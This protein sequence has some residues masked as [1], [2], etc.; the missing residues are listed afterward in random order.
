LVNR[1]FGIERIKV[2]LIGESQDLLN[3]AKMLLDEFRDEVILVQEPK[4]LAGMKSLER[5][6]PKGYPNMYIICVTTSDVVVNVIDKPPYETLLTNAAF[7]GMIRDLGMFHKVFWF[8]EM[9]QIGI[10]II[11]FPDYNGFSQSS[12]L[13]SCEALNTRLLMSSTL[14]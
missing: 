2:E 7:L 6:D 9:L 10:G 12:F 13:H 5:K 3:K 1:R 8:A 14:I 11:R 4:V